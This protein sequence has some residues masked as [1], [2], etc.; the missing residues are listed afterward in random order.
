MQTHRKNRKNLTANKP[1]IRILFSVSKWCTN[2]QQCFYFINIFKW[3]APHSKKIKY[4]NHK[5]R[6]RPFTNTNTSLKLNIK[7]RYTLNNSEFKPNCEHV[8]VTVWWMVWVW[9]FALFIIGTECLC[10]THISL[11]HS[12]TRIISSLLLFA[13]VYIIHVLLL[14]HLHGPFTHFLYFFYSVRFYAQFNDKSQFISMIKHAFQEI[15][16]ANAIKI[17]FNHANFLHSISQIDCTKLLHKKKLRVQYCW[18]CFGHW[19]FDTIADVAI[20]F[21]FNFIFLLNFEANKRI[22]RQAC[23]KRNSKI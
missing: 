7:Y 14:L 6:H 4:S 21:I 12:L 19:P 20:S 3:F 13:F 10:A 1:S 5:H 9:I 18:I 8:T 17:K 16:F 23:M 22:R 15:K 2:F 11:I